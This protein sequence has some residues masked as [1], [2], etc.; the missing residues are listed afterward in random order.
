MHNRYEHFHPKKKVSARTY[1][2]YGNGR[3]QILANPT[4]PPLTKD[5]HLLP[6]LF[7]KTA[8]LT[9]HIAA[10]SGLARDRTQLVGRLLSAAL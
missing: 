9:N 5:L 10:H 3:G 6:P 2:P 1:F 7:K 4:H 8:P